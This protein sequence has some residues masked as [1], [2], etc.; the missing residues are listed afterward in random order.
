MWRPRFFNHRDIFMDARYPIPPLPVF[1]E[2]TPEVRA[3]SLRRLLDRRPSGDGIWIF[4]YG[5]LMWDPCFAVVDRRPATVDGLRRAFTMWSWRARGTVERPGLGLGLEDGGGSCVGIAYRLDPTVEQDALQAAWDREMVTGIYEARWVSA[6]TAG[7]P[8]AA[9][10]FVIDRSHQQYAGPKP[11]DEM[12]EIM[13]GAR[14]TKGRC[15]DYLGNVVEELRKLDAPEAALV[16]L[17]A[18]V[19]AEGS[20]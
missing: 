18:R 6:E 20:E 8:V 14:G 3:A 12:A 7:G 1:H 5:S 16:D 2:L 9:I 19:D 13:A 10:T 15:R 17:L 4:A 11:V